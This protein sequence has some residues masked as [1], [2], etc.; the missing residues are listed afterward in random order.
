MLPIVVFTVASLPILWLSWRSLTSWRT[1]GFWRFFAFESILA[2]ILL[3]LPKWLADPFAPN[4][5]A[6]WF[7][8][9][10]S[11]VPVVTGVHALRTLGHPSA[12][13]EDLPLLGF[14][15]TTR[16][17]AG[18]VYRYIRHPMYSSLLLLA[19]GVFCKSLS[20]G[21]LVLILVATLAL[22]ATAMAEERENCRFFGP[23]YREYMTRT[24]RFLPFL[25]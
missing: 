23:T 8:L 13:R 12:A 24:N 17:V 4:Q 1:H 21:S 3:N 16:L 11:L 19:W 10:V 9:G 2:L 7:L 6:S 20:W 14:E 25:V 18:G 22:L 15:R 5:L